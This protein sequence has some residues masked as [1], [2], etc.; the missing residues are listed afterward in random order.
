MQ[1]IPSMGSAV[2]P[3]DCSNPFDHQL[4]GANLRLKRAQLALLRN[5]TG[6]SEKKAMLV[7]QQAMKQA[8]QLAYAPKNKMKSQSGHWAV[9]APALQQ[10]SGPGGG[11]PRAPVIPEHPVGGGG[12]PGLAERRQRNLASVK[13][14]RGRRK[15]YVKSLEIKHQYLAKL[16]ADLGT[17]TAKLQAENAILRENIA[18]L[19]SIVPRAAPAPPPAQRVQAVSENA[20]IDK[21]FASGL[22]P[23]EQRVVPAARSSSVNG[24]SVASTT[25][26]NTDSD[27]E[28]IPQKQFQSP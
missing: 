28:S 10:L 13:K 1:L 24:T 5:P 27:E 9:P 21:Y 6:S 16:A 18:F 8:W 15:A 11:F 7:A 20:E 26:V 22:Y 19:K 14:Y 12:D 23:A 17:Q 3:G 25:A 2:A 4:E